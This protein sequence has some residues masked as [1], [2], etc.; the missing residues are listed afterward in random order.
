MYRETIR[1][2]RALSLKEEVALELLKSPAISN[3]LLSNYLNRNYGLTTLGDQA[4]EEVLINAK[5]LAGIFLG[6]SYDI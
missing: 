5:Q 3:Q 4:F 6:E 2:P 1:V